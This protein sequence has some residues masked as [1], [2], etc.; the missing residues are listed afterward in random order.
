MDMDE[1]KTNANEVLYVEAFQKVVTEVAAVE[2]SNSK[3]TILASLAKYKAKQTDYVLQ[4]GT[5]AVKNLLKTT[6][7]MKPLL[8]DVKSIAKNLDERM[9]ELLGFDR[10]KELVELLKNLNVE[11]K[12][13]DRL[14]NVLKCVSVT[15]IDG[16][17]LWRSA[18][19]TSSRVSACGTN[20]ATISERLD[21]WP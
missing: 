18:D 3:S 21:L 7:S 9:H 10:Q 15:M 13:A 4:L 12:R 17:G 5:A 2:R 11:L 19:A 14:I 20:I 6:G 16:R 1:G 8:L